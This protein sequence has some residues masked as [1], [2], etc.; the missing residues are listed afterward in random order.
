MVNLREEFYVT[1]WDDIKV[2]FI[3]SIRQ[4][5]QGKEE[6]KYFSKAG[7]NQVNRKKD[8]DKRDI[9]NWR[10]ISLLN[11]NLKYYRKHLQKN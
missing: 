7:K 3:S 5:N 1:F 2:T 9:K 8:R 10:P 11:V 4:T 6:V